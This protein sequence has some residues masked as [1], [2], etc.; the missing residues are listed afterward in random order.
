MAVQASSDCNPFHYYLLDPSSLICFLLPNSLPASLSLLLLDPIHGRKHDTCGL[1]S[2]H[3][4]YRHDLQLT[5]FP[6]KDMSTILLMTDSD[7]V[8]AETTLGLSRLLHIVKTDF[9]A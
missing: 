1:E 3:S 2:P 8:W 7:A 6:A 9:E 5:P 4:T